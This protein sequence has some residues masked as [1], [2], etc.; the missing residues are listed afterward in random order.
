ME[1][2]ALLRMKAQKE[3][4][5]I[6]YEKIGCTK[7]GISQLKNE[8]YSLRKENKSLRG[9]NKELTQLIK[10]YKAQQKEVQLQIK[11]SFPA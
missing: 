9:K 8:L 10:W 1:E 5:R 3:A 7:E 4:E 2:L 11:F 6:I